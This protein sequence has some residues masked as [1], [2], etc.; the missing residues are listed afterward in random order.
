MKQEHATAG[1]AA[2]ALAALAVAA[3]GPT[4]ALTALAQPAPDDPTAPLVAAAALLAWGLAT[5]LAFVL[6][7]VAASRVPG[8]TGRWAGAVA[9]RVAPQAVRRVA[10]LALGLTVA[11]AAVAVPHAVADQ[12]QPLRPALSLDWPGPAP[13]GPPPSLDWP[14]TAPAQ[15]TAPATAQATAPATPPQGM[16]APAPAATP[17]PAAPAAVVVRPGDTLWDI[18]A[19]HLPAEAAPAAVAQAWPAWWSANRAA[20][21]SDPDLIHPGTRLVPPDSPTPR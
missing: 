4:R 16:P 5:W 18:A 1:A 17:E 9:G 2:V 7:A 19:D 6:L 10:E 8:W 11:T 14:G 21:G 15:A 3:P 20:I 13:I 12:A